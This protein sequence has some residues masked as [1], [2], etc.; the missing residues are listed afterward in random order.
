ME[1]Y[2]MPKELDF[3]N[4][5][6][7]IDNYVLDK[8]YIRD[9]GGIR[10]DGKYS[11]QGMTK[12]SESLEGRLLD[13]KKNKSGLHIFVDSKEVFCF[14][15]KN[16]GDKGFSLAYERIKETDDGIGRMI[17]LSHGEDPYDTSLPEPRISFLRHNFDKH[18]FEIFFKGRVHLKFH[19]WWDE[20]HWKYWTIITPGEFNS[21]NR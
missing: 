2:W 14:P 1:Q 13:F 19:S 9:C 12:V 8:L 21:M 4:L 20:P 17:M 11:S 7:C 18:L 3:E 6:K 10:E 5:R 16:Y 15:L